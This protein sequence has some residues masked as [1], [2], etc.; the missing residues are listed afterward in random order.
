MLCTFGLF[1]PECAVTSQSYILAV[2]QTATR[3]T[4]IKKGLF[5]KSGRQYKPKVM[6]AIMITEAYITRR[7]SLLA[8]ELVP[9]EYRG[10]AGGVR[11]VPAPTVR[12]D[13][14]GPR[15]VCVCH[16][17]HRVLGFGAP[18]PTPPTPCVWIRPAPTPPT[19]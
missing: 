7:S 2:D 5:S 12:L 18:A 13:S 14:A 17:P 3:I 6:G 4:I 8:T 1:K 15:R 9:Q 16:R 10:M 19:P 11:G